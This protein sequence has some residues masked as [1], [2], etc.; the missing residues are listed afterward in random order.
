MEPTLGRIL[1]IDDN[2]DILTAVRLLLSGRGFDV[3]TATR[4]DAVP[5]LLREDRYDAILLDMNFQRDASS[6][7]EGL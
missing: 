2:E 5:T 3:R 1:V 7:K 4:P 6:G